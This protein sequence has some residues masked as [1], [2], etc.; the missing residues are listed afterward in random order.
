MLQETSFIAI[1]YGTVQC[2]ESY[3]DH[4]G[5]YGNDTF[6]FLANCT[7]GSDS[8]GAGAG[9]GG[10]VVEP[11]LYI[12]I[13]STILYCIIF[14]VGIVGNLLVIVVIVYG[15]SMRTTVNKYLANLCV[16][17]VLVILVCMPTALADIFTKEIWYFGEFMCEYIH[18]VVTL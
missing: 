8:Y 12:V 11:P 10:T 6:M 14:I 4:L 9:G 1:M 3:R 17:D 2:N 15:R 5:V 13:S 16:A 7:N 18:V